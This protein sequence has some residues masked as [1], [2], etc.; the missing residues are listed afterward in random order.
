M[1]CIYVYKKI[2][3]RF[4]RQSA[5]I[6]SCEGQ[7]IFSRETDHSRETYIREHA[8]LKVQSQRSI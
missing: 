6:D 5:K 4:L 3:S 2:E 8:P 7:G 1:I